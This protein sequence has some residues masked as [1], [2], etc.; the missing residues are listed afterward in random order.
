[1]KAR[2]L[3][4]LLA[5]ALFLAPLTSRAQVFFRV[6]VKVFT[7]SNGN[8]PAGRSNA[9]IQDDYT[10]YNQLLSKYARGCQFSLTEIVQMPAS[11][12][13]WFNV[14]AR[15]GT[16]RDN[17]L[18]NCT[19]N[20][21]LYAYRSDNVNVYINNSSSGVCCGANNGLIFTGNEDDHITPV[22]EI[23]HM[24]GL[25][26]TQGSGCN[27]C[28]PD[29]LGCCDTPGDDGIADTIP[30][31]PCWS[32][33]QISQNQF[34]QNY[35]NL[36]AGQQDQVDDVWL[37]IMSYHYGNFNNLLERLTPGQMD[38]LAMTA[39]GTRDNVTG[40]Y[41]RFVDPF[42]VFDG[43]GGGLNTA[44]AFRTVEGA[45]TGSGDDDVLAI[46][47]GTYNRALAGVWRITQN[48]VLTSRN[49]LVRITKTP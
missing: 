18:A 12:S 5:M 43:L 25:S 2:R 11:L 3:F 29:P 41:F 30:D 34:S 42:S 31:L 40:N 19:S 21:A 45:I 24:L 23:G 17:L 47:A 37:N 48:R 38:Q 33:N 7:D 36:S 49:G 44:T 32:Q 10:Y 4:L 46:R 9:E 8:R 28:C 35:A 20:S 26:H 22:H 13:G 27:S 39:N 16:S 14:T 15:S 1:M 6:S